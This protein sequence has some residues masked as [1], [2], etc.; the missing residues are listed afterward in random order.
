MARRHQQR[1]DSVDALLVRLEELVLAGTGEDVFEEV[2]KLLVAKLRDERCGGHRRFAVHPEPSQTRATVNALL[3][4][5]RRE[6]P[7]LLE[8][9]PRSSLHPDHLQVCVEALAGYPLRD[10]SL[11]V[12]DAVLEMLVSRAA[13]GDKGQYF[14]PRHVIELC[15]QLVEP[16]PA[17]TVIDPACG[18]GGFLLGALAHLRRRHSLPP[19]ALER[20]ATSHL[21]GLDFDRRALR[22]A[23]ALLLFASDAAPTL[24]H[25]NALRPE[26]PDGEA[27]RRFD[28]VLT[29]PPFAGEVREPALLDRYE[30]ATPGRRIER[31]VLF[32]E[33]CVH[34]LRPGGRMAIVIPTNKLGATRW[35][36][37]RRWL[38]ARARVR[39][40]VA[41]GRETFL[42]HTHQKAHVMVLEIPEDRAAEPPPVFLAIS[43][44]SGKD[45]SGRVTL[46][47]DA[48]PVAPM[49]DRADHDLAP[50]VE[51]WR[52]H[53]SGR[54]LPAAKSSGLWTTRR[55]AELVGDHVLAPERYDP[56]RRAVHERLGG[57][58]SVPLSQ[59]ARAVADTVTPR[60]A[61]PGT[62]CLVL[63]TSHARAGVLS[64][65]HAPI[66]VE[67]L[68]S[69]KKR[70]RP[71]DVLISRLRPYLQQVAWVDD[72][73]PGLEPGVA[74]LCSTEFFVLRATGDAPI[75]FLVPYLLSAPV[76]EALAAG[77]EGGHHPR[78]NLELLLGLPVPK[79]LVKRRA[80]LSADVAEAC[81][82]FRQAADILREATAT[83]EETLEG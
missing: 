54:A 22:V 52:A 35:G 76:Q 15:V 9:P 78:F 46:L 60:R 47:P 32:I 4:E 2:F 68:G 5:A 50:I 3:D 64:P 69:T 26:A 12:V 42:P 23:R 61:P 65:A 24:R 20:W 67:A 80:A 45:A 71:G 38:L 37:L 77:Q 82:R 44:R 49:W 31:D 56:R 1:L 27:E 10:S 17:D 53:R 40:V 72:S 28:V 75:A 41:L 79:R 63:D 73:V 55:V 18:S 6:W 51:A 7:E 57:S 14:T 30:L 36:H 48:P 34:L 58:A 21:V 66:G 59:L 8:G 11:P 33:R 70:V 62:R 16:G 13:K 29:N 19:A 43:E 81:Q 25:T 83:V 74:L 39:A